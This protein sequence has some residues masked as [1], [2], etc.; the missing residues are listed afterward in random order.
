MLALTK[1]MRDPQTAAYLAKQRR[2]GKSNREAIRSLKRHLVRRV[3]H[4]LHDPNDVPI[5]ICLT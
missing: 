4:L 2:N 5:T 3:Y 1:I